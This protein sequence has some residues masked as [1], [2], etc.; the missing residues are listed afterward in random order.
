MVPSQNTAKM[1]GERV[2]P[3]TPYVHHLLSALPRR[4]KWVFAGAVR[5][6]GKVAQPIAKPHHAHATAC[7]VA[8]IEGLT[9]HG[10]R[11]SFRSLTEWLE[12]PAGVVAQIQGRARCAALG[13]RVINA[14][15]F[16]SITTNVYHT[17][18]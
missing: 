15:M 10:L 2:I 12:I 16:A 9:F 7:K 17:Q 14:P 6:P 5:E 11:R 8:D 4:S 13:G 3:L 1:E 18:K